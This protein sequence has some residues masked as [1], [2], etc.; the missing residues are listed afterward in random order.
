MSLA[1]LTDST[2]HRDGVA[3]PHGLTYRR[4][5]DIHHIAQFL[6]GVVRDSDS[7]NVFIDFHPLVIR[8]VTKILGNV[9][10][11]VLR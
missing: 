11:L 1:A 5:F 8:C 6:L 4:K 9:H 10:L 2:D 3:H 7:G